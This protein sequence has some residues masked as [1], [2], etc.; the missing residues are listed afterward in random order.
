MKNP[1]A[2]TRTVT[3]E[4][5][6]PG[7]NASKTMGGIDFLQAMLRGE[8]PKPPLACLLDF[9]LVSVAEG[10]AMF[11]GA[12]GEQ[13]YNPIGV[14]HGGLAATLL[15]SA[16]GCAVHSMLPQ[17]TAYTTVELH[18][19]LVRPM[20]R[21]TGEVFAEAEVIHFGRQMAT[22]QGRLIDSGGK[23]YAHGTTTCLIFP[24]PT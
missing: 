13:H 20:T 1:N 3:W 15:D 6:L 10:T 21:D 8:F 2:R 5:P 9:D 12:P 14:V 23:L 4:D 7:A 22:A 19:N 11:R 24:L 16:L 17:G 18:V